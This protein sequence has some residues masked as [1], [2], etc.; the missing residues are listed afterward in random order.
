MRAHP[1]REA[2]QYQGS[3]VALQGDREN[4][5]ATQERFECCHLA[6]PTSSR[7]LARAQRSLRASAHRAQL[8]RPER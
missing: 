8:G 1:S 3:P 6:A 2:I 7:T 5:E 4:R